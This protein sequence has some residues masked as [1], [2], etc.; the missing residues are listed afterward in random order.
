MA[1]LIRTPVD[2]H[3]TK[4][5]QNG[6]SWGDGVESTYQDLKAYQLSF[7]QVL[8]IAAV[9]VIIIISV[10]ACFGGQCCGGGSLTPSLHRFQG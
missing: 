8:F 3:R 10:C 2:E 7:F 1:V 4:N 6:G 9:G 5:W